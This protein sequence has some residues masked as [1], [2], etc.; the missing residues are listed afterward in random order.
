MPVLGESGG[1]GEGQ[2]TPNSYH[3][4]LRS[5]TGLLLVPFCADVDRTPSRGWG[6]VILARVNT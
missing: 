1:R 3:S 4:E 6:R 2:Q 5:S